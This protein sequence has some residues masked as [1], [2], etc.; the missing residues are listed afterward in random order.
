MVD[1]MTEVGTM[2]TRNGSKITIRLGN[3]DFTVRR[4]EWPVSKLKLDPANQRLQYAL[5]KAGLAA[6]DREL[7]EILW[8]ND[9]V[10]ALFQS[11]FQNGGLIE[12]PIVRSD[13][14]VV[15]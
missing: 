13:G 15:E 10:K 8:S 4:E 2:E 14:T 7:H 3:R 6:T 12:D 9:Q 1:G 11:V 5:R